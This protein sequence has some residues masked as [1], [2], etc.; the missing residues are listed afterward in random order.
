MDPQP[1]QPDLTLLLPRDAYYQLIHRLRTTLPPVSDSPEDIARR[2]NAAMA[3]V[4]CLLPANADE[5]DLAA[6]YVAAN[7]YAM[8]CLRLATEHRTTD[9]QKTLQCGAQATTAMRQARGYRSLLMR[10]QAERRKLEADGAA[11]E[12]GAWTEHCAVGFMAMAL[13]GPQPAAM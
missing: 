5:A 11:A 13:G 2:D 4:A 8:D 12:R 6:Q 1:Q 9:L 10:V 7:A 3:Q